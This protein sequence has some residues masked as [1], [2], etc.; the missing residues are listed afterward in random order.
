MGAFKR[1]GNALLCVFSG[2]TDCPVAVIVETKDDLQQAIVDNWTG[3]AEDEETVQV[4]QDIDAHDFVE[5]GDMKFE[6]EIGGVK[7]SDVF[8]YYPAST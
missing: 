8:S 7:I 4:M 3:D 5:K 1:K 2:E 6:F